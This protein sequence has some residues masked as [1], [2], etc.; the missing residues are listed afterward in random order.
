MLLSLRPDCEGAC[1]SVEEQVRRSIACNFAIAEKSI[2][3]PALA[4]P[5]VLYCQPKVPI[6]E[7][8]VLYCWQKACPSPLLSNADALAPLVSGH[9]YLTDGDTDS[10]IT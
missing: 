6:H 9:W 1:E 5:N 4:Q 10:K 8:K 2:R 7:P 3:V